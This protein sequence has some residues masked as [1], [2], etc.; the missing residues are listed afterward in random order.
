MTTNEERI[1]TITITTYPLD[2][3]T[4]GYEQRIDNDGY[5]GKG[6]VA[7]YMRDLSDAIATSFVNY[8]FVAVIATT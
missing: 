1:R 4:D 6:A 2:P 7:Q 3:K 5:E 8:F